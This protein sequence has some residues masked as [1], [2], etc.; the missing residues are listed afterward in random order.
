MKPCPEGALGSEQLLAADRRRDADGTQRMGAVLARA[1]RFVALQRR[2]RGVLG[3]EFGRLC[4]I[5]ACDPHELR[6]LVEHQAFAAQLRF[7]ETELLAAV[8]GE[9]RPARLRVLVRPPRV[10]PTTGTGDRAPNVPADAAQD[11]RGLAADEPDAALRTALERLAR[12]A[13]D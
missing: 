7:R 11:L 3:E 9:Y 5:V 10:E 12:R 8:S 2:L 1:E 4:H 13:R 6:L